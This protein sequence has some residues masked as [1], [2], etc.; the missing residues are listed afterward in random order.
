VAATDTLAP[1]ED[2]EIAD[3]PEIEPIAAEDDE[4]A[5]DG[6]NNTLVIVIG[7]LLVL[8]LAGVAF[9]YLRR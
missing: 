4:A 2:E 9:R 7:V 3:V 1:S 5:T 6:G 8:V